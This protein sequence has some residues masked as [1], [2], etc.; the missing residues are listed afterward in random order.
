MSGLR[1]VQFMVF[2]ASQHC[3]ETLHCDNRLEEIF[4]ALVGGGISYW[5]VLLCQTLLTLLLGYLK[6]SNRSDTFSS[7]FV[8]EFYLDLPFYV[9]SGILGFKPTLYQQNCRLCCYHMC[10]FWELCGL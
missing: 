1:S 9:S 2:S 6:I 3:S 5:Q 10:A 4:F 7:Q 8:S